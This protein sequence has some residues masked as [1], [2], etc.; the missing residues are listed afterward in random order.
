MP[1]PDHSTQCLETGA[2]GKPAIARV[3]S[4]PRTVALRPT[5]AVAN[6]AGH[7]SEW[8]AA[9]FSESRDDGVLRRPHLSPF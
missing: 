1:Q 9:G 4:R 2:P 6:F 7:R 3:P 5:A 8:S